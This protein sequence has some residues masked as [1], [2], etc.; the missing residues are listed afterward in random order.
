MN[1]PKTGMR[2]LLV[3]AALI[4]VTEALPSAVQLLNA[5]AWSTWDASLTKPSWQPPGW[6]FGV[7]WPILYLF[8]AVAAWLIWRRS[9]WNGASGA[10]GLYGVQ[11]VV[12]ALWTWVYLGLQSLS[13]SFFWICGLW[14]LIAV[15]M[16]AFRRHS[17]AAALLL[18]PYL[19]WVTFAAFLS[20]TIW[21]LNA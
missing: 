13:G 8:M 2:S 12:N 18:V 20:Y 5:D 19:A 14:L 10:L 3:L 4:I 11:L 21:R 16:T 1:P 7:V 9:G 17:R 6:A 15:T